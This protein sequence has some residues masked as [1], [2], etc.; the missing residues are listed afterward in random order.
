MTVLHFKKQNALYTTFQNALSPFLLKNLVVFY[1]G[2][3]PQNVGIVEIRIPQVGMLP[4]TNFLKPIDVYGLAPVLSLFFSTCCLLIVHVQ[5]IAKTPKLFE[6]D[7][8]VQL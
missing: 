6:L 2:Q 4:Y 7:T 1:I 3:H 8:N 5:E